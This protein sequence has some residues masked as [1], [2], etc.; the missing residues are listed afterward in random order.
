M[1]HKYRWQTLDDMRLLP[2]ENRK[3]ICSNLHF[4]F[5][6]TCFKASGEILPAPSVNLRP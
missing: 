2:V 4:N 5:I 3:H 1:V 6:L